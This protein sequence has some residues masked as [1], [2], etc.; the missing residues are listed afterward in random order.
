[1]AYVIWRSDMGR[2]SQSESQPVGLRQ[3]PRRAWA[4]RPDRVRAQQAWTC[5]RNPATILRVEHG[6][7]WNHPAG[8]HEHV[9]VL[10]ARRAQRRRRRA[11]EHPGQ[12]R[13]VD[14][15][16]DFDQRDLV[17][18]GDLDQCG[19]LG[20]V[21]ALG[22]EPRRV[23]GVRGPRWRRLGD[24]GLEPAL[25]DDDEVPGW[26]ARSTWCRRA[27]AWWVG[28]GRRSEECDGRCPESCVSSSAHICGHP[29]R[30]DG[31]GRRIAMPSATCGDVSAVALR[32]P[33]VFAVQT[34]GETVVSLPPA[35]A[36]RAPCR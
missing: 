20:H 18:P 1:M 23:E 11:G 26:R 36:R 25:V 2:S 35:P 24:Q 7:R 13:R 9:E 22:V 34:G 27:V 3:R 31:G 12:R 32:P 19:E 5:T 14:S 21:S 10:G 8:G 17:G 4:R 30:H 15:P 6:G 28:A 16:A 33:M 29:S